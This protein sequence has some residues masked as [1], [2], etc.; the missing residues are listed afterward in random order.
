MHLGESCIIRLWSVDDRLEVVIVRRPPPAML[1][2]L[3]STCA[4]ANIFADTLAPAMSRLLVAWLVARAA[5]SAD[6]KKCPHSGAGVLRER[7]MPF[8]QTYAGADGGAHGGTSAV[9]NADARTHPRA[10]GRAHDGTRAVANA[11]ARTHARTY[12][13]PTAEPTAASG[14]SPMPTHGPTS[15]PTPAPTAEP[16][17]APGPSTLPTPEPTSGLDPAP[18]CDLMT[19]CRPL[20][21]IAECTGECLFSDGVKVRLNLLCANCQEATRGGA[22]VL[23]RIWSQYG[24]Y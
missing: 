13:A 15:G 2:A 9:A 11:D 3:V 19:L 1:S 14:P 5:A 7:G 6:N 4:E 10:D 8:I 18:S 12:P 17:V 22:V 21:E 23:P 16:T 24:C 20:R